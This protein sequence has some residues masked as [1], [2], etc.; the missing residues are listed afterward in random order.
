MIRKLVKLL[1]TKPPLP[2][3]ERLR[4][5]LY[6]EVEEISFEHY[7]LKMKLAKISCKFVAEFTGRGE[8]TGDQVKVSI[9]KATS[10]LRFVS[11][12]I[13]QARCGH[14][15]GPDGLIAMRRYVS[16]LHKLLK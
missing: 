16:E 8:F 15:Y 1:F 2:D 9:E 13:I 3:E 6:H 7:L 5:Y 10:R 11:T 14:F 4:E 12:C